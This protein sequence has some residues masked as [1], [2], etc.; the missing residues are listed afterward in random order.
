MTCT[1]VVAVA[2]GEVPRARSS[3]PDPA[4]VSGCGRSLT[5][6]RWAGWK[7][8]RVGNVFVSGRFEGRLVA[9]SRRPQKSTPSRALARDRRLAARGAR[10]R[11]R[12][13]LLTG[14]RAINSGL[15]RASGRAS[16]P[17]RPGAKVPSGWLKLSWAPLARCLL[18]LLATSSLAL[19]DRPG[20]VAS[21]ARSLRAHFTRGPTSC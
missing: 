16:W 5:A 6:V 4:S 13:R 10:L 21:R 12:G 2:R 18:A 8:S 11:L 3:H 14:S 19:L 9:L 20:P 15:A 17:A 1:G 7:N